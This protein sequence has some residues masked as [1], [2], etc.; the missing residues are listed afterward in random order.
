VSLS[1]KKKVRCWGPPILNERYRLIASVDINVRVARDPGVSETDSQ[2]P[3]GLTGSYQ[4]REKIDL[5][6]SQ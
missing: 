2:N 6:L 4:L 5:Y 3:P 1:R